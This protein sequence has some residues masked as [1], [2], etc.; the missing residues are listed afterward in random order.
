MRKIKCKYCG[1]MIV[2]IEDLFSIFETN[3]IGKEQKISLHQHCCNQYTELMEYKKYEVK[4]FNEIYE[5]IK[6]LL[7]YTSEQK[8]PKSLIIRIQDLRNGTI[9]ERGIGRVNK[10]KEGYPY[11][12]ILDTFLDNGDAIR[13]SFAN[14]TFETENQKINYMMAI[15]DSNINNN[16][17]SFK[18]KLETSE[19]KQ[20][21]NIIEEEKILENN[22]QNNLIIQNKIIPKH[23]NGISSFL[24][25]DEF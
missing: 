19:I 7:L 24:N 17:I 15:I 4:W 11:Q 1:E 16:Y 5:H 3:S 9:I 25:D 20:R 22:I 2:N 18:N 6:E 8:L 21:D 12:I 23:K 14:K 13:W 10:S